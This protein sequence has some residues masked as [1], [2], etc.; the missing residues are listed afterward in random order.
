MV[1]GRA[2]CLEEGGLVCLVCE[3]CVYVCVCVCVC[4]CRS[5]RCGRPECP[6]A[7]V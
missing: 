7:Y 2:G 4:M 6:A 5:V 1:R 3:R